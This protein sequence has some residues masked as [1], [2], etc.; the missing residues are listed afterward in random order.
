[1]TTRTDALPLLPRRAATGHKGTFGTVAI[2]G[3]CC[4][5]GSRMIGAPALAALAAL[6]AGAGLAK[7]AVPAPILEAAILLTPSATGLD[8]PVDAAGHLIAHEAA[9]VLD[10]LFESANCIVIGP[11]MGNG[12]GVQGAALR[13][14]QQESVPVVVDADALNALAQTPELGRDFRA[15]T[16]LTPHPGEFQRLATSLKISHDPVTP[17]TRPFAAE[18]LAQRLGCVVV[19]KGAGTVV[20]DGITTWVCTRGHPCLGTAGTGDVLAG[21]IGGLVAQFARNPPRP[22][23]A[24]GPG[25]LTLLDAARLAVQAHAVAGEG[26]AKSRHAGAGM[27]ASELADLLPAVL[28][29]LREK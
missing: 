19:L 14:I 10:L 28:E 4:A 15:R 21:L 24:A 8:L 13:C 17:A 29:E 25:Q 1:L 22:G 18:A 20:S 12:E 11:G 27:L 26:W 2:V 7:L 9:A 3:G 6:R 16:I 23:A 5:G